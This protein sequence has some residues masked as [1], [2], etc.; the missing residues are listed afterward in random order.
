MAA[1]MYDQA[2]QAQFINT[3]APINFGELFRIGAA[4]KEEMDRAAQQFGAQLQKFGEFR[5]PSAVDTQ[6]YYD[7][8]TGRQDIQDAINQMVSNP[9]ALKDASFRS[10]LQSLINNIDYSSLSLLKESADNLRL[11]LQTRSK[12]MAE[13][14]YNKEWDDSD[15]LNYNTLDKRRVFDDI[16]PVAFMNANELSTPYFNDL[17]RGF[18]G[19]KY[20]NGT[21]YIVS[22][23]NMDDLYQVAS[24]KFNDLI[25]TPQGRKY[26]ESFIRRNGGDVEAAKSQFVDMIAQSQIDRTIRPDYEVDPSYIQELKNAGRG[27]SGSTVPQGLPDLTTIVESTTNRN[28]LAKFGGLSAEEREQ[29]RNGSITPDVIEKAMQNMTVNVDKI[30]N[31]AKGMPRQKSK[32]VLDNIQSPLSPNA[33]E[34]FLS[35]GGEGTMNKGFKVS[36]ETGNMVLGDDFVTG[37]IGYDMGAPQY[38]KQALLDPAAKKGSKSANTFEKSLINNVRFQEAWYSNK[39]RDVIIKDAGSTVGDIADIYHR[40]KVYVSMKDLR[41]IGMNIENVASIGKVVPFGDISDQE[42]ITIKQEYD[43]ETGEVLSGTT[44]KG[45]KRKKIDKSDLY[46]EVEGLYPIETGSSEATVSRNAIYEDKVRKLGSK[47]RYQQAVKSA[48]KYLGYN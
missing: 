9:D 27:G 41:N 4:Q 11:G 29:I 5:S 34:I 12:M 25:D 42:E 35:E 18:L 45:L 31:S 23:N 14:R 48:Y 20:I 10:S 22:G 7:L 36:N 37:I 13:G 39:F 21:R 8:T 17:K 33:G 28:M 47:E 40:R 16:T 15:I 30:F 1:N 38:I 32:T 3:Y 24:A 46:V 6:S 43:P 19:T 2:A 44:E 26:Y